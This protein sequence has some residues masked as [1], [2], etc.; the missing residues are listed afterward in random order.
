M[1]EVDNK[2]MN[3]LEPTYFKLNEFTMPFHMIVD[4]YGTPNYQEI[5]PAVITMATFPFL[6]GLMFGDIGHGSIILALGLYLT[7]FNESLKKTA[8]A[9]FAP[10]R[11]LILLLGIN[12][13][14][15]GLIYNEFFALRTNFFGSCYDINNLS[16]VNK[17]TGPGLTE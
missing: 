8:W 9:T 15:S 2:D 12:S 1:Q 14:F 6:F 13:V 11:Y 4:M 16:C 17:I 10:G 7:I 3:F 5:N